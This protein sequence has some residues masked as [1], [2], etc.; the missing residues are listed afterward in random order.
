MQI[1]IFKTQ[2]FRAKKIQREIEVR[3]KDEVVRLPQK[4]MSDVVTVVQEKDY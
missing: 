4:Q 2:F 3:M 1:I